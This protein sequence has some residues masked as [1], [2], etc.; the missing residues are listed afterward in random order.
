MMKY[1]ADAVL[2]VAVVSQVSGC[3]RLAEPRVVG[4]D[5]LP[6]HPT[7]QTAAASE[8]P[9]VARFKAFAMRA[10][11]LPLLDGDTPGRWANPASSLDC[12]DARVVVDGDR[13]D[14]GAP[15]PDAFTVRWHMQGCAPLDDDVQLT[16]DVELHVESYASVYSASVHPKGLLVR[17]SEGMHRVDE[18]FTAVLAHQP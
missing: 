2:I 3:G 10:L 17:T 12:D 11:L 5:V 18:P 15:V 9:A 7:W 8:S 4:Q 16:G 1:A 6:T 14:I 13:L